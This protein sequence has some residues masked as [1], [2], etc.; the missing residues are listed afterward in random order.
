VPNARAAA[1]VT[2]CRLAAADP[3]W[4]LVRLDAQPGATFT[5]TTVVLHGGAGSWSIVDSGTGNVGC[6][7]APQQVLAD[8]GL[9]CTGSGA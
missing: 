4:A 7:K 1:Q 3:T 2:A 5:P 6:G 8:L 9:L